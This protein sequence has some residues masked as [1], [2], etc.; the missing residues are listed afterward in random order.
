MSLAASWSTDS[1]V[2]K[3]VTTMR[4]GPFAARSALFRAGGVLVQASESAR[5]QLSKKTF[6]F[7]IA[8]LYVFGRVGH[9]TIAHGWGLAGMMVLMNVQGN[10]CHITSCGNCCI[11]DA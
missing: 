10:G 5:Q 9:D 2:A 11:Q 8:S 4:T 7:I 3:P 6:N 1:G